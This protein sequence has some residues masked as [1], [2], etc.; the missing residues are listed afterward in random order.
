V[1]WDYF[2][3]LGVAVLSVMCVAL[4]LAYALICSFVYLNP[5]LPSA[6]TM[7]N[8]EFRVPLRVFSRSGQLIAQIGEQRRIPVSFDQIPV[9]V[10]QAF[11]AAEDDRFYQHHGVD[12]LGVM[13]ALV[14]NLLAGDR[15]QGAST[16]TQQAARNM[17]L[18][19]DK[20]WRRKL[21]EFFVTYRMEHEFTKPQILSLYLNVIFLGQRSYGVAAA[22]EAYFGKTLDQL[23]VAEAATL[24]GLPQA[25]SR[26]NPLTSPELAA[27]RR[28]Y[29]LRRMRELG[30]IDAATAERA[31]AEP[32]DAHLHQPQ[33]GVDAPYI[34]EMARLEVRRRFGPQAEDA[35]Y[36]VYTTIDGRL[37][38]AANRALRLGLIEYDRRHGW[39]GA[40][41][42]GD[43]SMGEKPADLEDMLD[44]F[45]TVGGLSPAV[46]VSLADRSARLY[47][48]TTGYA[49]LDWP[50]MSWA[51]RRVEGSD[52]LGPEPK[53]AADILTRGD[54]VYVLAG[55]GHAELA[56]V[57]EAQG[58]LVA[59]DPNDGAIAALVGGFDY[60]ANKYNRVTQ[61]ER[62]PG[63]GF[64]PFLYSA[65]L[66]DGFT[67]ASVVMDAPIV[68]DDAGMED[69]WRPE[70]AEGEFS[71]P[72]RL[73]EALVHS[74]NLVSI[75][76]LRQMGL[77]FPIEYASR[78]GFD[79]R[80]L[81]HNLTLA[82]GTLQVTP[83]EVATG[84]AVFAN[85]GY[86][87]DPYY[88]DRIINAAG[89]TVYAAA[90]RQV[91]ERCEQPA[92]PANARAPD[93]NDAAAVAAPAVA[94]PAVASEPPELGPPGSRSSILGYSSAPAPTPA[95]DAEDA[96]PALRA[97]AAVRAAPEWPADRIAPRIISAPNAWIM[98][99]FM[100]D[101]I[102][103]G[104]GRRA[105]AL[106]RN[107]LS[108]KTGTTNQ[109]K[110]T[111]FNGF[112]RE[113]VATVWVGFDQERPLG[114]GEQGAR[115]AV[116]VWVNFMREA[117]KFVP[118]RPRP[119]PE[120]LVQA[121]ISPTTGQ[122]VSAADP[123]GMTE[124]FMVDR[125]P[126]GGVV[127]E[128][129]GGASATSDTSGAG[130]TIF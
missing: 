96:P 33:F 12:Y 85:G 70:D 73:R 25:P 127:G 37:Q 68:M 101:V 99:D 104:T 110:D 35:G 113:L 129:A 89:T 64:K 6:E 9:L 57:P 123:G 100:H 47:V 17:F 66:E 4:L 84:Y 23:D 95:P 20:T 18:T 79:P 130:Q 3:R 120:G 50:A 53:S 32:I 63:S 111:W 55:Q 91:C 51:R 92:D 42:H 108:G 77:D 125:L 10:R 72:T 116:P 82:L 41:S 86:R 107:D 5:S 105:L 58:A 119:M 97:A 124:T 49:E 2:R 76:V 54:I 106:G 102:T 19:L 1:K 26:Y 48:K 75:R 59:L 90:P 36:S 28:G 45:P 61:A 14:V 7:R 8:V 43:L 87:V 122:L 94:P 22:A 80:K 115:T 40:P 78:F 27:A 103:R 39:R 21:A 30:Y 121:R 60:F 16:I 11:I 24:A 52:R 15:A 46:V 71:G 31:R 114:E 128:P 112:N 38:A 67:P 117:L 29:V 13:R 34:A 74:L 81:P 65:A 93:A 62:Q 83:L 118:D 44:E 56:Q 98:D 88:I 109:A 126:S 69:T